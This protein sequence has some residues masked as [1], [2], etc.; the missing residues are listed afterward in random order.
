MVPGLNPSSS[1]L[2]LFFTGLGERRT[3]IL[4]DGSD[5]FVVPLS[6][7][8]PGAA[9]C[10]GNLQIPQNVKKRNRI[11]FILPGKRK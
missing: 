5:A 1:M 10:A 6:V 8:I 9:G 2:S 4:G 3:D 7:N 11:C